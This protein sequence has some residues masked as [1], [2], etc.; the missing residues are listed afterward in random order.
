[1]PA[2][3]SGTPMTYELDGEQY[4]VVAISGG[5]LAGELVAYKLP[6]KS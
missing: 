3:Q 2:P 4:I 6:S 5:N 1:M